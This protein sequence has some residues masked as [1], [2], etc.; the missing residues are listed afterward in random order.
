MPQDPDTVP[1]VSPDK[2]GRIPCLDGLRA[3]S[4]IAVAFGHLCGTRGF[5]IPAVVLL[6]G[7]LSNL[8]VRVF[9]VIS[10]FLITHLL[11]QESRASGRI[12][13]R[14]FYLRRSFRIFPAFYLYL[15]VIAGLAVSGYVAVHWSNI[16]FAACYVIN[17]LEEK[18]WVVGHFWSL[19][20][21][22]QFYLLWPI[23][24]V[25]L[26]W[27]RSTLVVVAAVLGAPLLRVGCW[28]L[29]PELREII[30]MAFPTICDA[31]AIGCVLACLRDQLSGWAAY[32]RFLSSWWFILVPIA[33]FVSNAFAAHTRPDYLIGQSIRNIGIALSLDWCLRFPNSIVGRFLNLRWMIWLGILSYSFYLWQQLFLNRN[34]DSVLCAFP[35]NIALAMA[36]AVLSF[37]LVEK[38]LRKFQSRRFPVD[39][40]RRAGSGDYT[41]ARDRVAYGKSRFANPEKAGRVNHP[42]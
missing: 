16:G 40:K 37:H 24:I 20:V 26:G 23:T 15:S 7:D 30:N 21:E 41:N 4:I 35:L 33:V 9:F 29:L 38:P 11:I 12:S 28:Y 32:Q 3:L 8:G 17:F 1:R 10:G 22:E 34:S 5:P 42:G 27:R 31:I 14:G 2:G 36:C 6:P 13:L 18:D 19:A 39:P 25:V